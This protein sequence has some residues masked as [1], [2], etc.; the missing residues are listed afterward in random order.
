MNTSNKVAN[1]GREVKGH[2]EETAARG[3]GDDELVVRGKADKLAAQ[4]KKTA[5]QAGDTAKRV[6]LRLK[7]RA[8]DKISEFHQRLHEAADRAEDKAEAAA[9]GQGDKESVAG[10]TTARGAGPGGAGVSS[11]PGGAGVSSAPGGAGIS[12]TDSGDDTSTAGGT[13]RPSDVTGSGTDT[14]P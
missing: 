1:T 12:S 8:L 7:E 14:M 11:A 5:A 9:A 13:T 4:T 10:S 6:G 2:V 3:F